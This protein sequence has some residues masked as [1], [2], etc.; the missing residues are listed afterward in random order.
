MSRKA[1]R[2]QQRAFADIAVPPDFDGLIVVNPPY[3]E[4]LGV[5]AGRLPGAW[6]YPQAEIR[7]QASRGIHGKVCLRPLFRLERRQGSQAVQRVRCLA[8]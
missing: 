3:G 6:R 7:T 2:F 4:R 5:R 8:N 1:S